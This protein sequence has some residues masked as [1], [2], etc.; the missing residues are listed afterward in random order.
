MTKTN[1]AKRS[2]L[3]GISSCFAGLSVNGNCSLLSSPV[4]FVLSASKGERR[5]FQQPLRASSLCTL[6]A[7]LLTALV[8]HG[9]A[10][11]QDKGL[12]GPKLQAEGGK[13]GLIFRT[14]KEVL[15]NAKKEGQLVVVPGFDETSFALMKKT[16]EKRYP[17]LKVDLQ[18]ASGATETEKTN[19]DEY[20]RI[21]DRR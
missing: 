20:P 15:E 16:F 4:P 12:P 21:E 19:R 14:K 3:K 17:F 1:P 13:K 8:F 2:S 6:V 18:V 9:Y 5:V 10:E 11:A 7:L